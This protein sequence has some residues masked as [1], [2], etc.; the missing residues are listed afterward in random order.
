MGAVGKKAQLPPGAP[1]LL[2][3]QRLR[4]CHHHAGK[5]TS[6]DARQR[7]V[8]KAPQ[9]IL[10]IAGVEARGLDLD[11]HFIGARNGRDHVNVA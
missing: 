7:G 10:H 1:N 5:V 8:G 2:T 6:R 11:Q 9:H 4:A 3:D